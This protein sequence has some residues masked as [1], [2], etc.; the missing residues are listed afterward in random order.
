MLN[1]VIPTPVCPTS[2]CNSCHSEVVEN[3]IE[4]EAED[5]GEATYE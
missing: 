2:P 1:A 5:E 4:K 3:E